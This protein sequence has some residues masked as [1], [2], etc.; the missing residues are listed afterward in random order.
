[1]GGLCLLKVYI[2]IGPKERSY[3]LSLR[4]TVEL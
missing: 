2:K 1:M 3:D 4:L